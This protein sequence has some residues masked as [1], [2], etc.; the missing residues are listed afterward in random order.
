[1]ANG[2]GVVYE[3]GTVVG[4]SAMTQITV[5]LQLG[6]QSYSEFIFFQDKA[7][8]DHFKGGNTE[9]SANASA[10]AVTAGAAAGNDFK[11]GLAVFTMPHGGLMFEASIGG[12]KFSYKPLK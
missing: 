8:L 12:Q 4:T 7:Q 9:F 3:R 5:G 6:G 1:M 11:D 10:V 2:D